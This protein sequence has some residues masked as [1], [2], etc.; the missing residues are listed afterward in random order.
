M[1]IEFKTV[2]GLEQ[3]CSHNSPYKTILQLINHYVIPYTEI[4]FKVWKVL[5]HGPSQQYFF[6][7]HEDYGHFPENVNIADYMQK[8]HNLSVS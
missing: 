2:T 6:G 3:L 5:S 4:D 8:W 1:Y 7:L